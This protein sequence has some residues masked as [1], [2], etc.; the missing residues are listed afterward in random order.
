MPHLRKV[1]LTTKLIRRPYKRWAQWSS[2]HSLNHGRRGKQWMTSA[3]V[4]VLDLR[5]VQ[6][7]M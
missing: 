5:P 1:K 6:E 2:Y 7:F 4:S 3:N